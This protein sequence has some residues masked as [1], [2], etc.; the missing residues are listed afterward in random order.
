MGKLMMYSSL[1]VMV[2]KVL[3]YLRF[4]CSQSFASFHQQYRIEMQCDEDIGT[5][6]PSEQFE[7]L[8]LNP[9]LCTFEILRPLETYLL[10]IKVLGR[11]E[12]ALEECFLSLIDGWKH[13]SMAQ[14]RSC[15]VN[16]FKCCN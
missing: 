2:S 15:L 4:A 1:L 10:V 14:L 8:N 6:W 13:T 16:G 7:K 3:L 11:N 9:P 5:D 12:Y